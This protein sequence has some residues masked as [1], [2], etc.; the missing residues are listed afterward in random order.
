M[1][2]ID[3]RDLHEVIR[4]YEARIQALKAERERLQRLIAQN[5]VDMTEAALL[6][7]ENHGQR[8]SSFNCK[9]SSRTVRVQNQTAQSGLGHG[10]RFCPGSD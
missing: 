5:P 3:N 4:Y 8:T 2:E 1:R 7:F 6:Q 10:Q 9:C